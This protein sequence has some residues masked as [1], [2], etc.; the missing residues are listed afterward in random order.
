VDR[1]RWTRPGPVAA[2]APPHGA[3]TLV[4]DRLHAP[5]HA[6]H[7]PSRR[8]TGS[9][10]ALVAR[11][12]PIQTTARL[13]GSTL[14]LSAACLVL[15]PAS[16]VLAG[17]LGDRQSPEIP[18][19]FAV[20]LAARV[21]LVPGLN[22][23][24]VSGIHPA[25][26]HPA[27]DRAPILFDATR[28]FALDRLATDSASMLS[29]ARQPS[30]I[31]LCSGTGST[32]K[33]APS[34]LGT[35]SGSISWSPGSSAGDLPHPR[36]PFRLTCA[37]AAPVATLQ[38]EIHS[39]RTSVFPASAHQSSHEK[40]GSGC[41]SVRDTASGGVRPRAT[42]QRS[43][44]SPPYQLCGMTAISAVLAQPIQPGHRAEN[45]GAY[46]PATTPTQPSMLPTSWR[47]D[48]PTEFPLTRWTLHSAI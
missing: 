44:H 16:H 9:S 23:S 4:H 1:C 45:E 11:Q 13:F 8:P 48:P 24:V 29:L 47:V 36:Q 19:T 3:G 10:S 15:R 41:R 46:S 37:V 38:D 17:A 30:P 5:Q 7:R 33:T 25:G 18:W 32:T 43:S 35:T 2:S 14:A 42:Q 21:L 26:A 39:R 20:A 28:S 6:G 22:G 31:A 12:R 34:S 27:L 40:S